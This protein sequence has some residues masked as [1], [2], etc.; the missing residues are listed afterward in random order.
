MKLKNVRKILF[1]FLIFEIFI[2]YSIKAQENVRFFKLSQITEM[3]FKNTWNN[4]YNAK[5]IDKLK[6]SVKLEKAYKSID[7]TYTKEEI[8]LAG[9]E[10][11][12][13]R[14]LT[15]FQGYYPSQ[16]LYVFLIADNH[17]EKACFVKA[18]TNEMSSIYRF[19]GSHGVMSKDGLWV[20]IEQ[21][22]CDNYFQ[23]EVCKSSEFGTGSIF[24][25]D[26]S[27]MKFNLYNS[28][29]SIPVIFWADKNTIYIST[30]IR[31]KKG[32]QVFQYHS[33]TF[34]YE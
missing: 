26:F 7:K 32:N 9:H 28:M 25:F 12:K 21:G 2:S 17:Y 34:G 4:N 29:E 11:I 13:P 20:G 15:S 24:K 27:Y 1:V 16:D 5:Y 14:G 30:E 22:D 3:D 10:L 18:S 19:R 23:I 8:E 31:D 33:L 6:D